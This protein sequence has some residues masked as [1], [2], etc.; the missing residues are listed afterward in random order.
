M[1]RFVFL[2][3]LVVLA[4]LLLVSCE[5]T[6][7]NTT[8]P[9]TSATTTA[10]VTT[11]TPAAEFEYHDYAGGTKV[12]ITKYK[13]TGTHVVIPQS[14]DGKPVTIVGGFDNSPIESVWIPHGVEQIDM[15]A[16]KNCTALTEVRLSDSIKTL[17][18]SA[19]EGCTALETVV[20]PPQL[21][22]M[23][24]K[25][26]QDCTALTSITIPGTLADYFQ[27]FNGCTALHTVTF[28]AGEA[29]LD[30]VLAGTPVRH[31][32]I[33][34]DA[35][36]IHPDFLAG[37]HSLESITFLGDAPLLPN[38]LMLNSPYVSNDDVPENYEVILYYPEDSEGWE[39]FKAH[40]CYRLVP[41]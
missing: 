7:D 14:I 40:G 12:W 3:L 34:G 4:V 10:P 23:Q 6:P 19:F 25:V 9:T 13:G 21:I 17:Q 8:A 39:S 22:S 36:N 11:A 38:D 33:E 31:I 28:S 16:F 41:Q 37:C 26:F 30:T 32:M 27:N 35:R 24:G 20:L 18:M 5:G 2:L 29:S 15:L 1:K